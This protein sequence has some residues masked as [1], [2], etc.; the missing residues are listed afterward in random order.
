[1]FT[2]RPLTTTDS[3]E[4]F[5]DISKRQTTLIF[6]RTE[7]GKSLAKGVVALVTEDIRA[8]FVIHENVDELAFRLVAE[9]DGLYGIGVVEVANDHC[10]DARHDVRRLLEMRCTAALLYQRVA[11]G[12]TPIV[13]PR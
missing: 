6:P 11:P 8:G 3:R 1:M 9:D 13:A 5:C 4:H 2:F 7:T 10:D 12:N